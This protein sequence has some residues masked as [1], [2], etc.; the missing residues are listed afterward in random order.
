MLQA[1]ETQKMRKLICRRGLTVP[2]ARWELCVWTSLR[3]WIPPPSGCRRRHRRYS[4]RAQICTCANMSVNILAC[5]G[6]KVSSTS[7][8]L[9]L[10][11]NY[12]CVLK[13]HRD[14]GGFRGAVTFSRPT[15]VNDNQQHRIESDRLPH[16]PLDPAPRSLK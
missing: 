2:G 14:R 4:L 15:R 6:G 5:T 16:L 10:Q 9:C 1:M 7:G 8:L 3:L 11:H 12:L 13:L